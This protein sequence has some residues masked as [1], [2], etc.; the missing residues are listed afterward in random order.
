MRIVCDTNVLVSGL[1][2]GGPPREVLSLVARG[3]VENCISPE[4]LREVADVLQ[5][6][7]FARVAA[8]TQGAIE[9]F[10]RVFTLVTPSARVNAVPEDP[11]DNAIL[12]A[13]VAAQAAH[14]ITGD[15]HLLKLVSWRGIDIVSP[16]AFVREMEEAEG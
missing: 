9:L 6:P 1:L 10:Q 8:K 16:A 13:A 7:K 14:V 4:I 5:R 12:E 3:V 11:D 2:F 15:R